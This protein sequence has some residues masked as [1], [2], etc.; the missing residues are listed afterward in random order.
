MLK[1]KFSGRYLLKDLRNGD[2]KISKKST[3]WNTSLQRVKDLKH[4]LIFFSVKI[5][6]LHKYLVKLL[7]FSKVFLHSS[8]QKAKTEMY[9]RNF[10]DL[11]KHAITEQHYDINLL[12]EG[13]D[14]KDVRVYCFL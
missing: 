1:P 12:K 9:V 8:K 13:S 7:F 11:V 14:S 3:V 6:I 4:F 2:K 10:Y 5:K